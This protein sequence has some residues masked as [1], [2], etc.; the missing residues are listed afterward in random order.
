MEVPEIRIVYRV[1]VAA[2]IADWVWYVC[3]VPQ[4]REIVATEFGHR[5]VARS[6]LV[7]PR[8]GIAGT[9]VEGGDGTELLGSRIR[10]YYVYANPAEFVEWASI[11]EPVI[12]A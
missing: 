7:F 12:F 11:F 9:V 6:P 1:R 4:A 10:D 8:A 2:M 5:E 3:P